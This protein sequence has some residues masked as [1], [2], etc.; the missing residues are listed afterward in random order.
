M[1]AE[2]TEERREFESWY[3]Q[4][5]FGLE[6]NPIGSRECGLKW[7]AWKARAELAAQERAEPVTQKPCGMCRHADSDGIPLSRSCYLNCHFEHINNPPAAQP[8]QADHFPDAGNMVAQPVAVP[9]DERDADAEL[10]CAEEVLDGYAAHLPLTETAFDC[11]GDYIKAVIEAQ[12]AMLAAAPSAPKREPLTDERTPMDRF[13][14]EIRQVG[15]VAA[16]EWFGH[17]PDSEFTKTTIKV[18]AERANG[19]TKEGN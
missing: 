8:A 19:V 13:E 17:A 5:A 10:N 14:N 12:A 15:V 4:T 16:C 11:I 7:T 2:Q 6:H 18:L 1:S 9:A 3:V